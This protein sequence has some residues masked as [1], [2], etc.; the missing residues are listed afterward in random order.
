M[1][2]WEWVRITEEFLKQVFG[3]STYLQAHPDKAAYRLEHSF[4]VANIGLEIAV[5]EGL[6]LTC[7]VI[8][9]LLHDISYCKEFESDEDHENHGRLSAAIARPFLRELGMDEVAANEVC[10]GIAIHVDDEA[11]FV[12]ERTTLALTVSDADNIDRFDML[13]VHEALMKLNFDDMTL[14]LKIDHVEGMLAKLNKL[15]DLPMATAAAAALWKQRITAQI[16][17]YL[18][19]DRQLKCSSA[20]IKPQ[21]LEMEE[22]YED[23][24]ERLS[25]GRVL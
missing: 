14:D 22:I 21:I 2:N 16:E 5:K 23:L 19:L 24:S 6:D 10:Y 20:V 1:L 15:L 9:C 12:G 18:A 11:D 25:L 13:R 17:F 4:R 7:T 3:S 8:A